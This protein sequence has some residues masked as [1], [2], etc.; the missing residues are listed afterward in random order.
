MAAE[1][2]T[3]EITF[4]GLCLIWP[5]KYPDWD[6][7]LYRG[8]SRAKDFEVLLVN[9]DHQHGEHDSKDEGKQPDQRHEE[10]HPEGEENDHAGQHEG[11]ASGF[12]HHDHPQHHPSLVYYAEDHLG[13]GPD[14]TFWDQSYS[15]SPNG[16]EVIIICLNNKEVEIIPPYDYE[17]YGRNKWSRLKWCKGKPEIPRDIPEED[18]CLDWTLSHDA[19]GLG[20]AD[21]ERSQAATIVKTP[22]GTWETKGAFRNREVSNLKAIRWEVGSPQPQALARDIVLRMEKLSHGPT[23]R[24]TDRD[25]SSVVQDITLTPGLYRKINFA[26]T[27]LPREYSGIDASHV[28]MFSELTSTLNPGNIYRPRKI[29]DVVCQ[30]SACEP[31]RKISPST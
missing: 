19:I 9:S 24:I 27:N 20:E 13:L 29:D 1:K 15:V 28:P 30:H 3:A 2:I 18:R 10:N 12:G 11:K 14:N 23:I 7:D 26:I 21:I 22:E 16:R 17:Y 4:S 6:R 8:P 5:K 31:T 25:D